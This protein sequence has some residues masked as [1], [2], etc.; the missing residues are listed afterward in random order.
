M[1]ETFLLE[2]K[3][4][5]LGLPFSPRLSAIVDQIDDYLDQEAVDACDDE[6]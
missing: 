4:T 1:S 3:N 6:S 5:F 2:L